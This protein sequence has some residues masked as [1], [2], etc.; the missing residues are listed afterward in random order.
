MHGE[1]AAWT[2]DTYVLAV[3]ADLLQAGNWQRGGGKGPRPKPLP[4]PADAA[5]KHLTSD[6]L[7]RNRMQSGVIGTPKTLDEMKE[8]LRAKNGR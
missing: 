6:E 2:A 5:T 1:Y 7:R 8:W 3:I 4:R